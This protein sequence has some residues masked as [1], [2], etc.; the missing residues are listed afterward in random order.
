MAVQIVLE[1]EHSC[2]PVDVFFPVTP[3]EACLLEMLFC[4]EARKPLVPQ[5]NR[6]AQGFRQLRCKSAN[7]LALPA[8]LSSHMEGLTDDNCL[9]FVLFDEAAQIP[10]VRLPGGSP[11]R[12]PTLRNRVK[13]V[14]DRNPD[15]LI[16]DVQS[17]QAHEIA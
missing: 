16:P 15:I 5:D 4:R 8:F 13:S 2:N 7:L 17:H 9:D 14:A 1:N 6:K 10:E 11:Q 3:L 12:W